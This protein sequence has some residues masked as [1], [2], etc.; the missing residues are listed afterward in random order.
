[1][2]RNIETGEPAEAY[3]Q[4]VLT[5]SER[6]ENYDRLHKNIGK[7]IATQFNWKDEWVIPISQEE[8]DENVDDEEGI[9]L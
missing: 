9:D 8:Y 7:N 4:T 5:L 3:I 6:P 1:M 2:A